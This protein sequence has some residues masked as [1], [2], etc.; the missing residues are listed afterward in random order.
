MSQRKQIKEYPTGLVIS[1]V[2]DCQIKDLAN[3]INIL[4]KVGRTDK[5]CTCN[6]EFLLR[7]NELGIKYNDAKV[8]TMH[9]K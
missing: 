2:A 9:I 4:K 8:N 6:T 1:T 7:T 3:I 5:F